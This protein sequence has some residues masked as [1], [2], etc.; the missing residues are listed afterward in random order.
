MER[1]LDQN[2]IVT[3]LAGAVIAIILVIYLV[4]LKRNGWLNR[5]DPNEPVDS[6]QQSLENQKKFT[7]FRWETSE[8]FTALSSRLSKMQTEQLNCSGD[9]RSPNDDD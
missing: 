3:V 2:Q 4:I 1:I 6:N 9:L 8:N 5:S 7:E